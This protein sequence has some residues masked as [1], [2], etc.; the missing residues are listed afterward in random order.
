[1]RPDF[2]WLSEEFPYRRW[3]LPFLRLSF[4]SVFVCWF[5]FGW[6]FL[7]GGGCFLVQQSGIV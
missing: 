4:S 7:R 1:L 5:S 3:R 2:A 6:F